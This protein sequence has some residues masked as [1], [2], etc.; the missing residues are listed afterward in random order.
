MRAAGKKDSLADSHSPSQPLLQKRRLCVSCMQL[1]A[2]VKPDSW[3]RI[4]ISECL[5]M[6]KM[7]ACIYLW[8]NM[9]YGHFCVLQTVYVN[10][11]PYNSGPEAGKSANKNQKNNHIKK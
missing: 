3:C 4:P 5:Y 6:N 9:L 2:S 8:Q 1:P 11:F 7:I 10:D